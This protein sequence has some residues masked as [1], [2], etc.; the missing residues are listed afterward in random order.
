MS[1]SQSQPLRVALYARVS[2][3]EQKQGQTIEP[4]LAELQRHAQD[5]DWRIVHT[6]KDEG[7]S[8]SIL[9]R[10]ELDRLR[11]EAGKGVFDAVLVNEVDRLARD[12]A[13]LGIIKRDLERKRVQLI[14]R[15]LPGENSPT[16][17]L[18][19]NILG[20]FAEFERALITDRTRRGRRYKVEFRKQYPGCVAPYGYRC[21]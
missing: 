6:Y 17:N 7:W 21:F 3:E 9:A 13:D 10:P 8:G 20:S 19:V 15:K 2:T 12:V 11:D 14:F 1:Q 16:Y 18:M 4:Q 5:K